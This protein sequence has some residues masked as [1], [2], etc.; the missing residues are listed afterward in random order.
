[1]TLFYLIL[2]AYSKAKSLVLRMSAVVQALLTF[3]KELEEEEGE[4]LVFW[5]HSKTEVYSIRAW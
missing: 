1:M 5:T 4:F 3:V 2:G